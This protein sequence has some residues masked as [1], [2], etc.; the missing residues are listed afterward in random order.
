[1]MNEL[2]IENKK[3]VVPSTDIIQIN[4]NNASFC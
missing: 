1:M 2:I 4:E 3:Q